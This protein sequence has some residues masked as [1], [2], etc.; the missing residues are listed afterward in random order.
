MMKPK[1]NYGTLDY[2][3]PNQFQED[4]DYVRPGSRASKIKNK[5]SGL[6]MD[7]R[8]SDASDS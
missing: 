4:E 7:N 1:K 6:N 3:I 2:Q 8:G 5:D